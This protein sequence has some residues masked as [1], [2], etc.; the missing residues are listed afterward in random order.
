MAENDFGASDIT[1]IEVETF[2]RTLTLGNDAVP[3]T[4]EA[5]QYSLP[6]CMGVAAVRGAPALLPLTTKS[7]SDT[8]ALDVSRRVTMTVAPDLDAMFPTAVPGRI[9]VITGGATFERSMMRPKGEPA[10]PMTWDDLDAKFLAIAD[11]RIGAVAMEQI[12]SAIQALRMGDIAPLCV[13]LDSK[14]FEPLGPLQRRLDDG[15]E[16]LPS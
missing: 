11:G 8:H 4:L 10:N 1:A 15:V 7:L 6:F 9:R 13:G 2:G 14:L 3:A 16:A 12:R 5:A